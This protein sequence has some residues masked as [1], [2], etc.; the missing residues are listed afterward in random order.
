MKKM[1]MSG[2]MQLLLAMCFVSFVCCSEDNDKQE[3]PMPKPIPQSLKTNVDTLI[4]ATS[5]ADHQ[6]FTVSAIG[7][8]WSLDTLVPCQWLH[9]TPKFGNAGDVV[10]QVNVDENTVNVL[11]TTFLTLISADSSLSLRVGI[12]QAGAKKTYGRMTDSLALVAVDKHFRTEW[13]LDKPMT[14]WKNLITEIVGGELRVTGLDFTY[15]V[16]AGGT[17]APEIGQLSELK[18]L[19]LRAIH[20]EVPEEILGLQKLEEF[21][22]RNSSGVTWNVPAGI[23]A[24]KSLRSIKGNG[25][26]SGNGFNINSASFANF[27]NIPALEVLMISCNTLD[28]ELPAGFSKL[29]HL[30]SFSLN[31]TVVTKLP[32]DF[33]DMVTL[34]EL[35]LE[36]N[37]FFTEISPKIGNLVNLQVLSLIGT[38]VKTLPV[39]F[40]KLKKLRKLD[41]SGLKITGDAT[42]YFSGMNDMEEMLLTRN[43]FS[44]SIAFVKDMTKLRKLDLKN[45]QQLTGEM[46]ESW[47]HSTLERVA[48]DSNL[49]TGTLAGIEKCTKLVDFS[50]RTNQLSGTM[51]EGLDK[52]VA[53][54][55]FFVHDNN[56]TGNL[57]AYMADPNFKVWGANFKVCYN[58][59]SGTI[60]QSIIDYDK[61][62]YNELTKLGRWGW[63]MIC[64]QQTGYGFDNCPAYK[65]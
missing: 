41:L 26:I 50:V 12:S 49:L 57:P 18:I 38:K 23:S 7:T 9:A 60:L 32:D 46:S 1:T 13:K 19:N 55:T 24:L 33:Y 39:E 54:Q 22:L 25:L 16:N 6:T 36:T 5:D 11:R 3:E 15:D 2:V 17:I 51:P 42:A 44:G 28:S 21:W 63:D 8:A 53:L 64:P 56:L 43:L 14:T 52:C 30:K 31:N 4:F 59:L 29:K 58:R 20:G 40:N 27:Y 47:F 61:S 35:L 62:K 34:E 37:I 65:K 48:L 10:V 45:N